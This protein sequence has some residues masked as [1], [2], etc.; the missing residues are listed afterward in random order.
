SVRLGHPEIPD[1]SFTHIS[2]FLMGDYNNWA[3]LKLGDAGHDG[4]VITKF[5]ITMHFAKIGK[6]PVD[7]I[8]C[9]R[10]PIMSGQLNTFNR[11]PFFLS[12]YYQFHISINI[13]LIANDQLDLPVVPYLFYGA[14]QLW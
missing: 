10:A 12:I 6:Y 14:G 5:S 13:L 7:E 9:I 1:L 11:L 8:H 2:T 3:P 4:R